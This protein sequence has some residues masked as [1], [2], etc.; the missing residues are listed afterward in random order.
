M[1]SGSQGVRELEELS[2]RESES[3][4]RTQRVK[5]L[6]SQ[7]NLGRVSKDAQDGF[8]RSSKQ[9]IKRLQRGSKEA[10]MRLRRGSHVQTL[11][12]NIHILKSQLHVQFQTPMS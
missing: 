5:E 1:E 3:K 6:E 8:K 9:V 12:S 4:S 11:I 10:L 7:R 2:V